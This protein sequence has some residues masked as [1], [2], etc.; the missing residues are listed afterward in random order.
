[1]KKKT[2]TVRNG[3]IEFWRFIFSVIIVIH[4]SRALLGDA[5]CMFLGGSLAVEF[6]F[7]VSGYLMMAS[8]AKKKDPPV[9]LGSETLEF[10]GRKMKGLLPELI[11]A[12]IVALTFASVVAKSNLEEIVMMFASSFFEVTQLKMSGLPAQALNG[13]TWYISSMLLCMAILYPL[14][15]KFPNVMTRV[16]APLVALLLLG[17]MAANYTAPRAPVTW[18]GLTYKGNLRAMAEI[19][20]GVM[21]YFAARRLSSLSLSV[22]GKIL[23]MLAEWACHIFAIWYMYT[24]KATN[25]DYYVIL[26]MMIGVTLSFSHQGID[27]KFFDCKFFAMLG[28]WSLPLFLCHTFFAQRLGKVLPKG[29]SNDQKMAVYLL[30]AVVAATAVHLISKLLKKC[31]PKMGAVARRV[32][33]KQPKNVEE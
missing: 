20:L 6:F 7:L 8:I 33:L 25:A 26:I 17:Y 23:I 29:L 5:N 10:I 1:M 15:R 22:V 13:V 28:R 3:K 31:G 9:A 4:H 30:C 32:L 21:C 2:A 19:C 14:I 12:Y 16:V 11:V 24:Q 27:A 18:L